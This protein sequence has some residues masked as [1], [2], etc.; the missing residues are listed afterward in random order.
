MQT[1]YSVCSFKMNGR[2]SPFQV[3][4]R[5]CTIRDGED[6]GATACSALRYGF[7]GCLLSVWF[8]RLILWSLSEYFFQRAGGVCGLWWHPVAWW[9]WRVLW[10]VL[11]GEWPGGPPRAGGRALQH[12]QFTQQPR[13]PWSTCTPV[14]W[15]P[16]L[17]PSQP[18]CM[19]TPHAGV[20][21]AGR[22]PRTLM[23]VNCLSSRE[24]RKPF[25][26]AVFWFAL[27]THWLGGSFMVL[28]PFNRSGN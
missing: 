18:H 16:V 22:G 27:H 26:A 14:P 6:L 10:P 2:Q 9:G 20:C 24:V 11:H 12:G 1:S 13:P 7:L 23:Y 21:R 28:F 8:S 25:I 5:P 3:R 19:M 15:V 17:T 4:F